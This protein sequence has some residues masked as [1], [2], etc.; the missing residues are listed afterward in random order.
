MPD[1][2]LAEQIVADEYVRE[3]HLPRFGDPLYLVLSD[4]RSALEIAK[5]VDREGRVVCMTTHKEHAELKRE[6]VHGFGADPLIASC[7]GAM[8]AV[9][10]PADGDGDEGGR[11]A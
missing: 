4:L 1:G 9:L 10:E 3:R 7:A 2:S 5:T 8:S 6:Q 11:D